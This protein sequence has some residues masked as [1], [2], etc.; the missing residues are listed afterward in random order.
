[1][2][3]WD[4]LAMYIDTDGSNSL[5]WP[6]IEQFVFHMEEAANYKLSQKEWDEIH[7]VFTACDANH[8]GECEKKEYLKLLKGQQGLAQLL[9][10]I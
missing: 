1:M 4:E 6:E 9:K 7:A 2:P 10:H 5:S 8:N 3:S